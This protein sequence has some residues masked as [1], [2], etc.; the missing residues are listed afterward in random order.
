MLTTKHIIL[1]IALGSNLMCQARS[2]EGD[3]RMI[4][5]GELLEE[6]WQQA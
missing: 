6:A 1:L 3:A 2:L 4:Y 5:K